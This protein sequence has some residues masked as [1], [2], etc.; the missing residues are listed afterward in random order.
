MSFHFPISFSI[1]FFKDLKSL[2]KQVGFIP[3]YFTV[4]GDI[5]NSNKIDFV[6]HHFAEI[7]NCSYKFSGGSGRSSHVSNITLT[8][9]KDNLNSSPLCIPLVYFSCCI[10]PAS[11]SSTILKRSR[12]SGQP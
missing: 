8:V 4:F 9:N 1:S 10:N 7:A 6:L 12:Y 11:A 3:R 5:V 2:L